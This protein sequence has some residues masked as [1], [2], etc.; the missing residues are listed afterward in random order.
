MVPSPWFYSDNIC[1]LYIHIM[2][3]NVRLDA[4]CRFA[5]VYKNLYQKILGKDTAKLFIAY[6]SKHLL[7]FIS[8]FHGMHSYAD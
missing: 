5:I 3:R 4:E 2:A 8:I 1:R 6:D 7:N